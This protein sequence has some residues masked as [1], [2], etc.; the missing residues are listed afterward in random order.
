M[1]LWLLW[2]RPATDTVHTEPTALPVPATATHAIESPWVSAPAPTRNAR[3]ENAKLWRDRGLA[4]CKDGQWQ[5]CLDGL[6]I[7]RALDPEG[8][9]TTA[10]KDARGAARRGFGE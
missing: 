2:R 4:A 5:E 6:D 10:V 9:A 7:A 3:L 8:D 1:V